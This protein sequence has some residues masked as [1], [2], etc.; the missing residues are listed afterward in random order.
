[1]R[2]LALILW[3]LDH[4]SDTSVPKT[5]PTVHPPRCRCWRVPGQAWTHRRGDGGFYD[6]VRRQSKTWRWN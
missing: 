3:V 5:A 1:M 4:L 6:V 2:L